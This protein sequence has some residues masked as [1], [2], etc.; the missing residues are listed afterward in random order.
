MEARQHQS[1]QLRR[2]L[3]RIQ[4]QQELCRHGTQQRGL[5][6]DQSSR[7]NETKRRRASDRL[8]DAILGD[9]PPP[10]PKNKQPWHMSPTPASPTPAG[11]DPGDGDMAAATPVLGD[12]S[13]GNHGLGAQG[14]D[15]QG[16][17]DQGPDGQGLGLGISLD[18]H[19]R[20]HGPNLGF[21]G[22]PGASRGSAQG[23]LGFN[24][25]GKNGVTM[26][27][28]LEDPAI[29]KVFFDV[30]SGADAL[31][32]HFNIALQGV[33]D[34]QLMENVARRRAIQEISH[35][36]AKCVEPHG[37]D[38]ALGP[39]RDNETVNGSF[40]TNTTACPLRPNYINVTPDS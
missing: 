2:D 18:G 33:E 35:G 10:Q 24:T 7:A 12:Q 31:Y 39:W 6:R 8:R 17:D 38:R 16:P 21:T 29:P 3:R 30:R 19:G 36:L 15:D 37:S 1:H 13:L 14:P 20:G 22:P 26:K 40:G 11:Q 4:W 23:G 32:A 28:I 9:S 25:S 27:D 5:A 34:V